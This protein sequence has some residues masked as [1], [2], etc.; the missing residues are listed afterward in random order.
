VDGL[1][2]ALRTVVSGHKLVQHKDEVNAVV[3]LELDVE[4][5]QERW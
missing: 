1:K 2:V 4:V 5:L 3:T